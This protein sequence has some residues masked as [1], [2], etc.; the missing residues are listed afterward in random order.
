MEYVP[1]LNVL[2]KGASIFIQYFI[3]VI[4]KGL[5]T[6]WDIHYSK[7]LVNILDNVKNLRQYILRYTAGNTTSAATSLMIGQR[8]DLRR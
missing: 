8:S 5:K 4:N 3:H 2:I 7:A 6:N 1:I